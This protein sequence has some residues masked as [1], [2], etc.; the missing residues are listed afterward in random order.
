LIDDVGSYPPRKSAGFEDRLGG[1][2]E[3]AVSLLVEVFEEKRGTGV[4]VPCYPQLGDMLEGYSRLLSDPECW[5]EPY[6][7]RRDLARK[8]A[9]EVLNEHYEGAGEPVEVKA[10]FTGPVE[11]AVAEVGPAPHRDVLMA[12]AETVRRFGER[13]VE[14]ENLVVRTVSIDEPSLGTNPSI[15]IEK[16]AL[17]ETLDLASDFDAE[18]QVHLH[19]PLYY[20]EAATAGIDVIGIETA[21]DP[22][23][24]DAV[25]PGV[26]ESHGAHLRVGVARTDSDAMAA[27]YR[28]RTGR[29]PWGE[30]GGFLRVV[31]ESESPERVAGRLEKLHDE[32]GD[33]IRYVG[34]DCGLSGFPSREAARTLLEN[35]VEGVEAFRSKN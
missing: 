30:D 23:R 6:V 28:G 3:E 15:S 24:A 27:D 4:D 2:D 32:F 5:D 11:L 35:V 20:R 7:V 9:L 33:R 17:I 16:E 14:L 10:A 8:P 34:P 31:R 18:T 26:L 25:D 13:V 1:R 12:M 19:S 29:D 22:S 21:S